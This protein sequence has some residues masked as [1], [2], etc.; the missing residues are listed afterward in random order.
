VKSITEILQRY[1]CKHKDLLEK[2]KSPLAQAFGINYFFYWYISHE[3][4]SACLG[5]NPELIYDYFAQ[6]MHL[7]NPFF[8]HV[9][10]VKTGLYFYDA[11]KHTP[12][13]NSMDYLEKRYNA[14][15]RCIVTQKERHGLSI[16]GFSIPATHSDS[17]GLYQY[18][19]QV[20]RKFIDYCKSK[21][22]TIL[23][24]LLSEAVD[25]KPAGKAK[26]PSVPVP[27]IHL[28]SEKLRLFFQQIDP[29][30]QHLCSVTF[31]PKEREC[32]E[33]FLAGKTAS[34]IALEIKRSVRT[35]E[36]RIETIKN[37][38]GCKSR[39]ELFTRLKA[40]QLC[41]LI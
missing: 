18:E 39:S 10:E 27:E 8:L 32:I 3:Q 30:M 16:Y 34:E 2:L 28:S 7:T 41:H 4:K 1:S 33:L 23:P 12:F 19:E 24:D 14:K 36:H 11:V 26:Y 5:T 9:K 25:L 20:L 13:Q 21:L 37:K 15:H 29:E 38:L 40:M 17:L 35:I 6:N 22:G 31:S